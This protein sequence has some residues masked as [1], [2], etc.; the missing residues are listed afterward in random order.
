M[1]YQ[2]INITNPNIKLALMPSIYI[3]LNFFLLEAG[4]GTYKVNLPLVLLSHFNVLV[5]SLIVFTKQ[6][7][8]ERIY[9]SIIP[10]FYCTFFLSILFYYQSDFREFEASDSYIYDQLALLLS[11][12]DGLNAAL[13]SKYS[14]DDFGYP[15]IKNIFLAYN[16]SN[17]QLFFF[18]L[19]LHYCTSLLIVIFS[20]KFTTVEVAYKIGLFYLNSSIALFF[21]MSGLKESIITFLIFSTLVLLQKSFISGFILALTTFFFRKVYPLFLISSY[22]VLIK[23]IGLKLRILIS[24]LIFLPIIYMII[25]TKFFSMYIN[26]FFHYYDETLLFA[27]LISGL[28]G[29]LVTIDGNDITNYIYSPTVFVINFLMIQAIILNGWRIFYNKCFW[30]LS[31]FSFPLIILMQAIKVR[32]LAPFY[33]LYILF[34]LSSLRDRLDHKSTISIFIFL[35]ISILWNL[36]SN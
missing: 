12:P 28:I 2:K 18:K 31:I 10:F 34:S 7:T 14:Y 22:V 4:Y 23:S 33:G 9:F 36:L 19:I 8:L 16:G 27:S 6:N 1:N 25:N 24:V 15:F 29:G 11:K 5:L 30:L 26:V 20:K 13:Q 32:Y 17:A 21:L 35:I 3:L